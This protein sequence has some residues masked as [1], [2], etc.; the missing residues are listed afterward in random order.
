MRRRLC[1][2][3]VFCPANEV[4]GFLDV[5]FLA[6]VLDAGA[7][8]AGIALH[9]V[10]VVGIRVADEFPVLEFDD[11]AAGA[12]DEGA[13]VRDHQERAWIIV[14]VRL[15]TL[16]G[17]QVQVVG[18]LVEQ[19]QVGLARQHL[20]QFQ[21][22]AFAARQGGHGAGKIGRGQSDFLGERAHPA[23]DVVAILD[24]VALL[25][26][27]VAL[28]IRGIR[29]AQARFE[30]HHLVVHGAQVREG[31]EQR[32]QD[33]AIAALLLRLFEVG[34]A[35]APEHTS[36]SGVRR[37]LAGEQFEHGGLAG[38]VGTKQGQP[39]AGPD[40]QGR[41]GQDLF[42]RKGKVNIGELGKRHA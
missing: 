19:E 36:V 39:I 12:L 33:R 30:L 40:E 35:R 13:V 3:L 18:G 16:D 14:E 32:I 31:F 15:Q 22:T 17:G 27:A 6:L 29:G 11:F 26:L 42:A 9:H 24:A 7:L 25:Q 28:E 23:F 20:G 10:L 21:T 2:C 5:L 8:Q 38:S 4:F 34:H 41:A 37:Q 1:A